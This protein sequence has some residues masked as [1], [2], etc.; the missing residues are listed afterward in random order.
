VQLPDEC[1]DILVAALSRLPSPSDEIRFEKRPIHP[2]H[3]AAVG[4]RVFVQARTPRLPF[5]ILVRN[6]STFVTSTGKFLRTV[7]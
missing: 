1:H 2:E 3:I 6:R 5:G 7:V 4:Q